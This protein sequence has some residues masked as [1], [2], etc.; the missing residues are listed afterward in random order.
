MKWIW[1]LACFYWMS[2]GI[3]QALSDDSIVYSVQKS[4][5]LGEANEEMVKDFYI[6]LGT[7]NGIRVGTVLEVS[8]KTPSYDLTSQKLY[9]DIQFSFARLK[10]IHAEKDACIARL[11]RLYPIEKTPVVNPRAVL[12]GDSVKAM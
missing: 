7:N 4:F 3:A 2:T 6:N 8:R 5:D 12:V 11:E 1:A 10:V 9:K